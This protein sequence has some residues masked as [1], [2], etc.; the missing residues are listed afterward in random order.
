MPPDGAEKNMGFFF[1]G[2]GGGAEA[3]GWQGLLKY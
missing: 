3:S 1:L 2:G